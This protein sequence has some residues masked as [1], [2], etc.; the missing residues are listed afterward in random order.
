MRVAAA[1]GRARD[2]ERHAD[3]QKRVAVQLALRIAQLQLPPALRVL[4]LGCGTGFLGAALIDALPIDHYL[5]TDLAPEMVER[6]RLRFAGRSNVQLAV[7]DAADPAFTG[8]FDLICSSLAMQ[9]VEDLPRAIQRLR[10]MLAP[11]GK[12][13][14]TTLAAGSFAEWRLAHGELAVGTP[15]YPDE[16]SLRQMGLAVTTTTMHRTY[17]NAADFLNALKA[18]GAG[19]PR[20]GY[21]P[22][23]PAD[24][25]AV[26]ARFETLGAQA[27]YQV[28]TCIAG[29]T[30]A[31]AA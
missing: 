1:F 30:E 9:W 28:A 18:I 13:A 14:F 27:T 31:R 24:L 11:G 5:M 19:T 15:D 8:P 20:P 6:A 2:Y 12:L 3:V 7:A 21:R 17:A 4:E 29:P 25:R 22:L 23:A 26:M 10:A 16:Q